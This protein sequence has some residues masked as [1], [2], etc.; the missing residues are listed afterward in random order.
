MQVHLFL[1]A[2]LITTLKGIYVKKPSYMTCLVFL[3]YVVLSLSA[4]ATGDKEVQAP[5]DIENQAF[6]D[7][8]TKILETIDDPERQKQIISQVNQLQSDFDSMRNSVVTRKSKLRELFADYDTTRE[9]FDEQITLHDTQIKIVRKKAGESHRA[10]VE[11]M[12]ND[13]WFALNKAESKAM[14]TLLKSLQSI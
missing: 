3:A 11:A 14:N 10:L 2:I 6:A 7:L 4:C 12:T 5:E 13:E 9:K 1:T 8:R